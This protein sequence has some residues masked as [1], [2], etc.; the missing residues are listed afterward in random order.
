MGEQAFGFQQQA[1]MD[2]LHGSE[3]SRFT[4]RGDEMVGRDPK[5]VG[6]VLNLFALQVVLF[7]CQLKKVSQTRSCVDRQVLHTGAIEMLRL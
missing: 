4:H 1:V 3:A 5:K 6:V 2:D 7:H